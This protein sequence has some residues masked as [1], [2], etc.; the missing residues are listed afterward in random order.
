MEANYCHN[1]TDVRESG[2]SQLWAQQY[3]WQRAIEK[4]VLGTTIRMTES[5]VEANYCHNNTDGRESGGS[6]LW[7]QQYGWQ[8]ARRK[9]VMGSTVRMAES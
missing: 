8:R 2:G 3:G 6:K 7:A 5:E 9:S 4:P 1:T